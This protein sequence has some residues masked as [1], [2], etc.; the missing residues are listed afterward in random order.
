M[1][2]AA[3]LM[4]RYQLRDEATGVGFVRRGEW[5]FRCNTPWSQRI[6]RRHDVKRI[7]LAYA[8]MVVASL[9]LGACKI[10]S[11]S[12]SGSDAGGGDGSTGNAAQKG[13][14]AATSGNDAATSS[15]DAAISGKD[16]ATGSKDAATADDAST[17]DDGGTTHMFH[18][19][20]GGGKFMFTSSTGIPMTFDFPASAAGKDITITAVDP[21]TVTFA[22]TAIRD[23]F[24]DV[25]ELGPAGTTFA[26]PVK[27]TVGKG[28]LMV[29]DYSDPTKPGDPLL[30]SADGKSLQL[31]H[32]STLGV[33]DPAMACNSTSGWIDTAQDQQSCG[34]SGSATTHR[35]YG[36]KAYTFCYIV[37]ADCCVAPG[38]T[39]TGCQLGDANLKLTYL[40]TGSNGGQNTYCDLAGGIGSAP[41]VQSHTPANFTTGAADEIITL[42]GSGFTAT[43]SVF[44]TL[45]QAIATTFVN[46]TQVTAIVPMSLRTA[47]GTLS[48]IGFVNQAPAA[49]AACT[50]AAP[51]NCDWNNRSNV[52]NVPIQ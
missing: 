13:K 39:N 24:S 34:N 5:F 7:G 27:V 2:S 47:V 6:L 32:F 28:T 46:S 14:D 11:Q 50:S 45:D 21:T 25:I 38:N 10:D 18:V 16:A 36:C 35:S 23:S 3:L 44:V 29:Y 33:V 42:N 8:L 49:Q 43:G 40:R 41:F 17:G 12:A 20:A 31:M 52:I 22:A 30:L 51:G 48:N 1:D 19:P 26:T 4:R 37:A 9:G 15:K